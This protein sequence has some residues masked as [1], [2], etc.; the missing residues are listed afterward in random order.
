M[1]NEENWDNSKKHEEKG[2]IISLS[3][4]TIVNLLLDAILGSKYLL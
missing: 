2:S 3:K 1:L 4:L